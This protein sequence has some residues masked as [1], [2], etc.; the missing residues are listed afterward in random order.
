MLNCHFLKCSMPSILKFCRSVPFSSR[1]KPLS[2]YWYK[3]SDVDKKNHFVHYSNGD[4][5]EDENISDYQLYRI[6]KFPT[7]GSKI[8]THMWYALISTLRKVF[9][10]TGTSLVLLS[11]LGCYMLM[12]DLSLYCVQTSIWPL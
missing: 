2:R 9:L 7:V 4:K 6:L 8:N 5:N 1:T 3:L 10:C 12:V 11:T